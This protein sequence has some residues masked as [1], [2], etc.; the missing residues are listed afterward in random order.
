VTTYDRIYGDVGND[1]WDDLDLEFEEFLALY[2]FL[3]MDEPLDWSHHTVRLVARGPHNNA[4]LAPCP[5][6]PPS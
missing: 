5:P 3:Y 4:M 1:G 2:S 6:H